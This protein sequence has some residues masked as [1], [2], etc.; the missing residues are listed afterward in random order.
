MQNKTVPKTAFLGEMLK[1]SRSIKQSFPLSVSASLSAPYM[2][3]NVY[4]LTHRK[5]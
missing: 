2:L 4:R 3:A 5:Y 1:S